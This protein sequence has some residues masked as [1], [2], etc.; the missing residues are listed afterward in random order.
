MKRGRTRD[1][2]VVRNSL[3]W[4]DSDAT[5]DSV[6]VLA[7]AVTQRHVDVS[8][9]SR[10]GLT[11]YPDIVRGLAL[12]AWQQETHLA[13]TQLQYYGEKTQH[14]ARF[15]GLLIPTIWAWR[16]GP[17]LVSNSEVWM[18]ERSPPPTLIFTTC[19]RSKT[20]TSRSLDQE[21]CACLTP[22]SALRR[23]CPAAHMG[24]RVELVLDKGK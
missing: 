24:S 11:Y 12:G 7:C 22:I 18:S 5:W 23:V 15:A 3:M 4:V 14:S 16:P 9:L 21:G 2:R 8:G 13:T 6:V 20:M 10:T 17:P 19:T 1:S